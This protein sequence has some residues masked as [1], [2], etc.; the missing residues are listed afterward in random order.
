[1]EDEAVVGLAAVLGGWFL[2][3]CGVILGVLG[4]IGSRWLF[5]VEGWVVLLVYPPLEVGPKYALGAVE[6]LW[7]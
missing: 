7:W 6:A 2:S 1:M 4:W 3:A 5:L